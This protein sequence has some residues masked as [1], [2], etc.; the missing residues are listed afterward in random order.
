MH[1]ISPQHHALVY[2]FPDGFTPIVSPLHIGRNSY[3]IIGTYCNGTNRISAA[4]SGFAPCSSSFLAQLSSSIFVLIQNS[5]FF[6]GSRFWDLRL[7][8]RT[9]RQIV[10]K[11]SPIAFPP[12]IRL[13]WSLAQLTASDPVIFLA[14]LQA[15]LGAASYWRCHGSSTFQHFMH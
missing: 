13:W 1:Q 6:L 7:G 11:Y 15:C 5:Q 2:P 8:R 14:R 12:W 4:P 9:E 10:L 3:V